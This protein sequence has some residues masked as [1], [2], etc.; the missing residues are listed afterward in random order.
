MPARLRQVL[1][2]EQL[3]V[4][5]KFM[6]RPL[7]LLK[8]TPSYNDLMIGFRIDIAV[9]VVASLKESKAQQYRV[10]FPVA[11]ESM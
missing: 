6:F 5:G 8:A 11:L 10:G 1:N 3:A 4:K 9:D 7:R 2:F